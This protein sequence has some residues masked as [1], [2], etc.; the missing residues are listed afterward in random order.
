MSGQGIKLD[1]YQIC[2]TRD[3]ICPVCQSTLTT[4]LQTTP[5]TYGTLSRTFSNYPVVFSR[6]LLIKVPDS[7]AA[8]CAD[9]MSQRLASI[10]MEPVPVHFALVPCVDGEAT[11]MKFLVD[12][13]RYFE[14][15]TMVRT[16]LFTN[17][18]LDLTTN[19]EGGWNEDLPLKTEDVNLSRLR[20][21][22]EKHNPPV[23]TK[24]QINI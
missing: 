4:L 14:I 18:V 2:N 17:H 5:F 22:R 19:F 16:V 10:F 15:D 8:H 21:F 13:P 11:R 6:D 20:F 23:L 9:I 24:G 1:G 3:G 12:F 7:T